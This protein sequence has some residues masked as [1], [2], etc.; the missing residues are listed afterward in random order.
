M[1]ESKALAARQRSLSRDIS[2]KK[3]MSN[4]EET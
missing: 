1:I 4:R 3:R 2:A